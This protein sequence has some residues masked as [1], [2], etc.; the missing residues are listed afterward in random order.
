LLS[1]HALAADAPAAGAHTPPKVTR[2]KGPTEADQLQTLPGFKVEMILKAEPK[3]GSWISMGV[4]NK[5][6]LILGGQK[7]QPITRVTLDSDGQV[8]KQ[9][10]MKLP[11]SEAMGILY[12]FD[13][14]YLNG[15]CTIKDGKPVFD[16]DLKTKEEK[17]GAKALFGLFRCTSSDGGDHYDKIEF[18]REWKGG[19][20]E[21]GAH[22]IVQGPDKKLYIVIGNF[23][24]IPPDNSPNAPHRNYA[25]DLVLP[26]SEDGNGF[27][28]GK[29]PPGGSIIRLDP[30]GSHPELFASG[31]RN[32]YDV[33]FNADGELFG[34][35]SDMEWDWGTPWY[36]PIRVFHAISGGDTGF[37]EGSGKWPEYYADSLPAVRNI[38][39]GCPTGV[40]FGYGSKFPP[41]YQKAFYI[42]DWTYGRLIAAHL[43][44]KGASYTA[45]WE[46]FVWPKSLYGD[47]KTP[48]S[49]TDAVIAPDGAMY[50]TVGG[51]GKQANLFR[52]SYDGSES[53]D[54]VNAHDK[55]GA[56]A[57]TLR[58]ELEAFDGKQDPKAV[59]TAWK[60]LGSPDRFL[61]YAARIAIESQPVE[62]WR[63]RAV[64][65]KDAETALTALLALARLG[66]T[67][68]QA[69]VLNSLAKFPIA[70]LD[71]AKKLEKLRVIE[72]SMARQGKPAADMAKPIIDELDAAFPTKT[73]PLNRE[74]SQVL[75]AL[76]APD[77]VAKTVALLKDA[78][79][80][81]EQVGYVQMLRT[82]TKGWTPE[83]R[84]Q[85]FTWFTQDRK[86]ARHWDNAV[87]WFQ[88]AGIAYSDG[89]SFPR[90][91]ASFHA[92]AVKTLSPEEKTTLALPPR[93][94]PTSPPARAAASNPPGPPATW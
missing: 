5:G 29:K 38:G 68:A 58:H 82:I 9:E 60:Q 70:S 25:D 1:P 62:Q 64:A 50:F 21:H 16:K 84:Q 74:L 80:Q 35:D 57:R 76:E 61:R 86:A 69:D 75:L 41:K 26:R 40:V 3:N 83:L 63:S 81:E 71:P 12:A 11:V 87:K 28:A 39:I 54:P 66:G 93:S 42:L 45:S 92:D 31:Q 22:A 30:D 65:E 27:G 73:Y 32:T 52:V 33:A 59:E 49:L 15:W 91:I 6:R 8:E 36:R 53:I 88:D 56:E 34:F 2:A 77:A 94:P 7:G 55:N 23:T 24:E 78:R 4:D 43:T 19:S 67:E 85:Y 89:S 44:P 48:L 14:L 47:V 10:D 51:R 17:S 90:F 79:S 46:N 18:L 37:R 13:S 72:V 20:G